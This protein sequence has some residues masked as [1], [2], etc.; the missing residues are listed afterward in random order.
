VPIPGQWILILFS[1]ASVLTAVCP[2][3]KIWL[4]F[5]VSPI[6]L[7]PTHTFFFSQARVLG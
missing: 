4:P 1:A 7:T 2:H 6:A 3:D 5:V